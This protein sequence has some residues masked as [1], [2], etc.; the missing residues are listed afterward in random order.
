MK[1]N[2]DALEMYSPCDLDED[3]KIELQKLMADS[4]P[5]IQRAAEKNYGEADVRRLRKDFR[6]GAS[7]KL[8]RRERAILDQLREIEDIVL[9]GWIRVTSCLC[10]AFFF[11]ERRS[12]VTIGDYYQESAIAIY[13]AIY[14]YNG[15]TEFSNLVFHSV[16]NALID[17][18]RTEWKGTGLTRDIIGL[19]AEVKIV[20]DQNNVSLDSAVAILRE[21]GTEISDQMLTKLRDSMIKTAS[22]SAVEADDNDGDY[23][24]L[25]TYG[26]D[27]AVRDELD[28]M[29]E[30]IDRTPMTEF[31][32][33]LIDTYIAEGHGSQTT[34]AGRHINPKTEEPYS[35]AR[36]YQLFHS[37]RR[38]IIE[39]YDG[40]EERRKVA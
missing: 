40:F 2:V 24:A 29:R 16:K 13:N 6:N 34:V 4:F 36:A 26:D 14:A 32:R 31:E 19:R 22:Q 5:V 10:K 37:T 17:F 8:T 9:R 15:T 3:H 39:T 18:C 25:A 38:R 11:A 1:D 35:R 20:M 23:T 28:Q 27:E 30:A 7:L 12:G 21:D 33:D